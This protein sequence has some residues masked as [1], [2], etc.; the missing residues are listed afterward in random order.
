MLVRMSTGIS[1]LLKESLKK[2]KQS[3][4]NDIIQQYY[5]FAPRRGRKFIILLNDIVLFDVNIWI[6]SISHYNFL[7]DFALG[8]FG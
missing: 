2:L 4:Q 1:K 7:F 8:L 5:K 6:W 3:K